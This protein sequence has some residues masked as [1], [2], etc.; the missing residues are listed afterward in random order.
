VAVE[1]VVEIGNGLIQSEEREMSTESFEEEIVVW[2]LDGG[3]VG[4][5]AGLTTGTGTGFAVAGARVLAFA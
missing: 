1:Q 3:D 2:G 4:F 5:A